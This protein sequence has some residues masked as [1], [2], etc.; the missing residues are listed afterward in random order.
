MELIIH[1]EQ[2]P[3]EHA[4]QSS[5]SNEK[6]Y[7]FIMQDSVSLLVTQREADY[8]TALYS[9]LSLPCPT[10]HIR[11]FASGP[12]LTVTIYK[13][14]DKDGNVRVVFQGPDAKSEAAKFSKDHF[15]KPMVPLRP[16]RNGHAVQQYP[17]IG[18]DE[19][20]TGDFFGP[21]VVCAALVTEET[22]PK[23]TELGVTDSK[24]MSDEIIMAI[25]PG[26]SLSYPHSLLILRNPKYNEV[27][28]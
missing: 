20:G 12:A 17:Q 23:L 19:V 5:Q 4:V 11:F 14:I 28:Q 2:V 6:R 8:I 26:L 16:K 18:S 15:V 21:I 27:I 9:N 3:N 7:D 22:N 24:K 1:S 25:G 10:P 13:K